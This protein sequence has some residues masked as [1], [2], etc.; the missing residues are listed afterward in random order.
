M[1]Q[2]NPISSRV[3]LKLNTGTDENGN[4]IIK[5]K[6]LGNLQADADNEEVFGVAIAISELQKHDVNA[7]RRTDEIELIGD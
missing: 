5:T 4:P 3:T 7:V 6:G 1:F 2:T